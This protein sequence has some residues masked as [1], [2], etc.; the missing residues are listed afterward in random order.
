MN[1]PNPN[2]YGGDDASAQPITVVQNWLTRARE[3]GEAEPDAVHLASVD[4]QGRP[5]LRVVYVRDYDPEAVIFFSH[6][7]GR[8]G[9]EL[10]QGYAA[11]NY[12][13]PKWGRQIRL[14]GAVRHLDAARS[15]AY[16]S[17]R[18]LGSRLGAWMSRQST[19]V[20]DRATMEAELAAIEPSLGDRRPP[21]WGGYVLEPDEIEFWIAGE[22]RIHDRFQWIKEDS[23][24]RVDRLYP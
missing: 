23:T 17:S 16:F 1:K 6:Y 7:N 13:F 4:A 9:R 15:D 19:P 3:I 5:N 24:W 20:V 22:Y 8:K 18:P 11:I 14:R 10:D 21:N 12:Y 2:F